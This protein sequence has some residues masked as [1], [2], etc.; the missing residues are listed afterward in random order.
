MILLLAGCGADPHA[1]IDTDAMVIPASCPLLPPDNPWNTDIS[2]LPVHP[3]SDAFIDHIGRDGALHPD[4]GTEWRGVPNGIPYVVVPA[5]QPEVPVSFTWAD[6]SD[7]GP[8]PI[9]PDAPIEGGSRGGG[10]RHVIVL[11]SGSCTLYE[12]FNARPHDGGTRWDADSGAVFPLDTNDL[13]PDGWTSADAAGLPILP[14][15]VRYQEVVEAGEIRHALRF[16]VVTSQRG[17]ILPATHAA[18][19]TDDADAPP[20][21]LR[22]RMKSGF[23]CSALSTEVQ[24]VCAALKTYGMFVADNGSDWYLSG[25]PDP[26]WSDDALRDL[27]AIPGDAFE[28][29]D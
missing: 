17:Y 26:R 19:S 11:E 21:G 6:E 15:L 25:A 9:P 4:F 12:L 7:A 23:D 2:A 29:V 14:G 22:L 10:D 18:G 1:I 5:S 3:G 20:M 13:R 8:Y 28:V 24:V 27:G 16:T